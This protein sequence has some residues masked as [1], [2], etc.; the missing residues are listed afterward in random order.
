M[1]I[2]GENNII[3][4]NGAPEPTAL[5]EEQAGGGADRLITGGAPYRAFVTIRGTAPLLFHAWNVES[6]EEKARAAKNSAT[7]K[8][9]DV[10]SYVYRTHDGFLG[11]PGK[12][13]HAAI[14][15]AGRYMPDPRSPRKSARDL[16]RAG[17]V[18][19]TV[20]AAFEPFRREW[21]YLD[22]Q[23]VTV[24]RAGVT[25]T[26]P[27]MLEGWILSFELLVSVP[28]Y[29][30]PTTLHNLITQAGKLCGLCDFRPT[31]GRFQ[32]DSFRAEAEIIE[33]LGD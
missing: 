26:R 4:T 9:D 23:R 25:R 20:V 31:Y 7:K 13:M 5:A 10:N 24:Q 2:T 6:V 1:A 32:V 15:E 3:E 11:V 16:L 28:E 22:R 18:P 12:N 19:L 21:D 29:V 14:A 30:S 17:I 33:Q 27:A 8:T